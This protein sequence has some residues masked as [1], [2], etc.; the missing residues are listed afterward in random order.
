MGI[1]QRDS[2]SE[3]GSLMGRWIDSDP[4]SWM[5]QPSQRS[6]PEPGW[7]RDRPPVAVSETGDW[8]CGCGRVNQEELRWVTTVSRVICRSCGLISKKHES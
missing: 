6:Q 3:G 8:R 2:E 4:D 5:I 7:Y 1:G